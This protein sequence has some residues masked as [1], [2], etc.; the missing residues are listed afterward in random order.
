MFTPAATQ[1]QQ[2]AGHRPPVSPHF[3]DTVT[4]RGGVLDVFQGSWQP[5][6][7]G[8]T[9]RTD[10]ELTFQMSDH[11][12]LWMEI[13]TDDDAFDLRQVVGDA[14]APSQRLRIA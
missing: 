4:G 12:P 7:E 6:Y 13:N 10:D 1:F 11:L 8:I 14:V 2:R 9:E 5:L 3:P